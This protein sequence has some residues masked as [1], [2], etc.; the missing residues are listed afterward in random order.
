[1]STDP[2][3]TGFNFV[4][5]KD[6]NNPNTPREQTQYEQPGS[7][8]LNPPEKQPNFTFI[9]GKEREE[10]GTKD[11]LR[12]GSSRTLARVGETIAGLP[13]DVQNAIGSLMEWGAAKVTGDEEGAAQARKFADAF[14][15]LGQLPTSSQIREK[16]SNPIADYASGKE[17]YLNPQTPGE[18]LYDDF[19]QDVTA[20][21]IPVK[22]KIPFAR[23]L[24]GALFGNLGKEAAE[25]F[26]VSPTGANLTKMGI[27]ALT[28][29]IGE[30]IK[31][32]GAKAFANDLYKKSMNAIPEGATMNS[33]N[34]EASLGKF[35]NTLNK[36]GVTAQKQEVLNLAKQLKNRLNAGNGSIAVD[37]LPAFRKS[38]SD[39]R[40]NK[41][42]NDTGR[43]FLDQFD[44][45][46]NEGLNEYGATNPTFLSEYRDANTA[47]AG[48]HQSNRIARAISKKVDI[49]KISPE[50]AVLL[51]MHV[52]NP[53][54]LGGL[55]VGWTAA[56]A[57]QLAHRLVK[58]PVLQRYYKDV[59]KNALSQ[60]AAALT[61]SVSKLDEIVKAEQEKEK[62]TLENYRKDIENKSKLRKRERTT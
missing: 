59:M 43:F 7:T 50:T 32:G 25:S 5:A 61:K 33:R 18:Q 47:L 2:S 3:K 4:P 62:A 28:G 38:V 40:F 51:G 55:G 34:I 17:G 23:A 57:T 1:M 26:G 48:F 11:Y 8:S 58:N 52:V 24:G 53:K 49:N 19:V 35:M 14:N 46:L 20:L 54:V 45:V 42:L 39:L 21:A 31:R 36:G 41:K 29:T 27:M 60:D 12:R 44:R 10:E 9:P 22:G 13:G 16:I 6:A 30:G 56:K 37:E 15:P